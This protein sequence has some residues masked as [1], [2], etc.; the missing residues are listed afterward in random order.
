MIF[1]QLQT[2]FLGN[3]FRFIGHT[4]IGIIDA[5][6]YLKL[7]DHGFVRLDV[8]LSLVHTRTFIGVNTGVLIS[9]ELSKFRTIWSEFIHTTRL[10]VLANLAETSLLQ[11]AA[12]IMTGVFTL[13]CTI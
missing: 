2:I 8:V 12:I 4:G 5:L 11:D 6:A 1:S 9:P 13:I 10:T 7:P 3:G